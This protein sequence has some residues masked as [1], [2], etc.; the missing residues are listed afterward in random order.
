MNM[1]KDI[2]SW[3][4]IASSHR[5]MFL[6]IFSLG[7]FNYFFGE[8]TPASQGLGWDG[9]IYGQLVRG[10]IDMIHSGQLNEY[11]AHRSLPAFIVRSF[12][13]FFDTE[14]S[15]FNIVKSFEIFNLFLILSSVLVWKKIADHFKLSSKARWIGFAGL[16]LNFAF[17]KQLFYLPVLTDYAALLLSLLLLLFYVERKPI[18][19]FITT[20]L[21]AFCWPGSA[22][23]GALLILFSAVQFSEKIVNPKL[24]LIKKEQYSNYFRLGLGLLIFC[25]IA[26]PLYSFLSLAFFKTANTSF[27][28]PAFF[29][30]LPVVYLLLIA[31]LV[32]LGSLQFITELISEFR[33]TEKI[34]ALK[35]M[36]L[37]AAAVIAPAY[38]VGLIS[39]PE[40][41]NPNTLVSLLELLLTPPDNKF[42]LSPLT[43]ILL[44]GPV[45]ILMM[46]CWNQVSV[47][48]RKLGPGA[49][50]SVALVLPLGL[51]CE[52]RFLLMAWPFLIISFVRASETIQFKPTFKLLF[53][54]LVIIFSQFWL[55]I[56]NGIWS[57]ELYSDLLLFPKQFLFMHY[58]LW[59]SWLSY[60]I[61]L[62]LVIFIGYIL[63]RQIMNTEKIN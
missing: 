35:L 39:N 53:I 56:N 7:I 30:G 21:A 41:P 52:P 37:A 11:Y 54:F 10:L 26:R 8:K 50:A 2:F 59:M 36:F 49:V 3:K 13:I 9:V 58:G 42:F 38:L 31:L 63:H 34:K 43:L 28:W 5:L 44:W 20:V 1:I 14:M 18:A 45:L 25:I 27:K 48:L 32:L 33:K 16:F 46:L 12:M 51:A 23:M 6:I 61:Q 15:D 24:S 4:K 19:M 57:D 55:K 62:P 60:N 17:S 22:V 40:L 47:Q 29:T